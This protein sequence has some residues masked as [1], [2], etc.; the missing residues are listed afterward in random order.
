MFFHKIAVGMPLPPSYAS[1]SSY[2]DTDSSN[3]SF[4]SDS[5]SRITIPNNSTMIEERAKWLEQAVENPDSWKP[6][7]KSNAWPKESRDKSWK[8]SPAEDQL[9]NW[10][11]QENGSESFLKSLMRTPIVPHTFPPPPPKPDSPPEVT[12]PFIYK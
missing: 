5:S 10:S 3:E 7:D 12:I 8:S 4:E 11:S 6:M 9:A 1:A 2:R